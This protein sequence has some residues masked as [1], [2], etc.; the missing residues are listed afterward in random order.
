M[1]R[2]RAAS[3]A[4]VTA[5]ATLLLAACGG[6]GGSTGGQGGGGGGEASGSSTSTG[7]FKDCT[8]PL[9]CNSASPDQL[10]Q[11]GQISFAIEKNIDNWNLNSSEG[12]VFETG[13]AL[14]PLL[15]Y[16]YITTPDLKSTLNTDFV[17]SADVTNQN[18]FTV[19]YKINPQ[20]SWDDGTPVTADDFAFNWKSQNPKTCPD[21]ET[22]GNGGYDIIN[23]VTGSDNGKTVTVTFDKAYTDWKGI[24]NS[25][26][27]LYPAH[28]AAQHGD[29]N[30]PAGVKSAFDYFGTQVPN[31]TAGPFKVENWEANTALTLVPNPKWW[32]ATKPK[33]DRLVFR[34]ITDATQE[35]IA[36]QNNEVQVIYPQPQVDLVNQVSQI[37]NVSQTQG[38]GLTWEH[39]DFNLVN[40]FLADK[41]LRQAMFTAV[42]R[43][44]MIDKTVGQFNPDVKPLDNHMFIPQQDGYTDNIGSTG[45]GTGNLDAA[46]KILTDAKYTGVGTALVAPNGQA[47]PAFRLRYT[48][49]N[50][51]RQS[52]CEL[53]A[54]AVKN[55]GINVNIEPTTSLGDTTS[56]G[57]FDII[58]FAW[59]Q[60]PFVFNGAQQLWLSTSG[61]NYGKYNNPQVD[62]LLNE[63]AS[64]TD[65]ADATNKLN[66]ADKILSDDAYVLP[67]YQKPTFVA[68]QNT[69]AN[70]RNNSSLDSPT[71]NAAEWGLRSS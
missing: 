35:P 3:V 10:Q 9:T 49:G 23:A 66:Q 57:D 11:G 39:F 27:P 60:S 17:S 50:A 33:L 8:D 26:A 37:P 13:V 25:A 43:Q 12:N 69:V 61:S 54:A 58:V 55:L 51:I 24:F 18:P 65:T 22:A 68:V 46:K 30:T 36:L 21:C 53:F 45:Q 1:R 32:G 71:Y 52:E 31:Y 15:P 41:A 62:Q 20:A 42:D 16:A 6:G 7:I 63:A 48:A 59:V 19:T 47:V 70:V 44:A 2:T 4:A 28:I 40:T 14:K 29:L 5:A 38:L 34:V 67:L 64:D 56:T